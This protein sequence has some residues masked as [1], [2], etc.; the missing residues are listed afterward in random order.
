MG[1]YSVPENIRAMRPKGTEVKFINGHYYVYPCKSTTK[2]IVN[3]DGTKTR[4][5]E[6]KTG[7][8]IG[9]I[10][11]Q[12]G[13]IP[14]NTYLTKDAITCKNFG[15]YYFVDAFSKGTLDSL[16][17]FFH[18]DEADKIY[19]ISLIFLVDGFTYM[20]NIKSAYDLS[21]LSI[22]FPTV[23]LGYDSIHDLYHN[24][25]TRQ[26]R[27]KAFEMAQVESSSRKVAIDGHVVA[28]TSECNDLSEFGYKYKKYGTKQINWLTA[29]DVI[30]KKPML[31]SI[32]SGANPDKTS[33]KTLF[34]TY[35]F[36]NT[37]FLVDRGFNTE[38]NKNLMSMNGNTYIVPMISGRK[39]YDYV[40]ENL[41]FDKRRYFVFSKGTHSSMIYYQELSYE[42]NRC[43]AFRDMTRAAMERQSFLDAMAS[44]KSG[45][46]EQGLLEEEE[47]FGLFLL[48][49]NDSQKGAQDVFCDYKERWA[50]ETYY[51]YVRNDCNFNAL[52]QQDY[53]CMEGL[54]FIV[55]V[56]GILYHN[57]KKIADDANLP[58][59]DVLNEIGKLKITSRNEK[60]YIQ[61][62][63]RKTRET[64]KR[65][66]LEVPSYL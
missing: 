62:I 44:G 17:C 66:G 65:I 58:L 52:Y 60:W 32:Y 2:T 15:S 31:S 40:C 18:P 55:T 21:Y 35:F 10:T 46:S 43:I 11:E 33:V 30:S 20:K 50:I 13:F 27:M 49:T 64:C 61:N 56:S 39:D 22:A 6:K 14:N 16:K 25:G 51:N 54:S 45:Y 7:K 41:H 4:R 5:T 23:A 28:C 1:K 24:L 63:T 9:K 47:R 19:L 3:E 57:C 29:Y 36:S 8:S 48:E 38:S 59:K 42:G 12:E 37:L 53:F 34:E 26:E